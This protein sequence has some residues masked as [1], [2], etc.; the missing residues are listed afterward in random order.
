MLGLP[1]G[2]TPKRMYAKLVAAHREGKVSFKVG[3][4][5]SKSTKYSTDLMVNP[6]SL[7]LLLKYVKTFNMDEYV[8]L[9]R[10]HRESYHTYMWE[11]LFA[12]IDIQVRQPRFNCSSY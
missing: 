10:A 11:S 1:T 2:G 4:F 3:T 9:P 12:H 8:K 6:V 5:K 7:L